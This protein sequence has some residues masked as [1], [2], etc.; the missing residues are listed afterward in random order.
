MT[1]HARRGRC[2]EHWGTFRAGGRFDPLPPLP[3]WPARWPEGS[4]RHD[5]RPAGASRIFGMQ[6]C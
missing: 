2:M 5:A 1:D 4:W 3:S 6:L